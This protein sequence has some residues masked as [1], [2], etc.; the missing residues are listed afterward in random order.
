[1]EEKLVEEVK[2]VQAAGDERRSKIKDG[3]A[4]ADSSLKSKEQALEELNARLEQAAKDAEATSS[5]EVSDALPD[6]N[7]PHLAIAS[8]APSEQALHRVQGAA[9]NICGLGKIGGL[10]QRRGERLQLGLEP[11]SCH[12]VC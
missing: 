10:G 5:V 7:K 4:Q 9:L 11:R 12:K 1:V 6:G 8:S 2:A 3:Y